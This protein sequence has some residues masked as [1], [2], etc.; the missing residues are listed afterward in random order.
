MS[1][2]LT[3]HI[4][5]HSSDITLEAKDAWN[6]LVLEGDEETG[7]LPLKR[8]LRSDVIGVHVQHDSFAGWGEDPLEPVNYSAA[9]H[10][11][12]DLPWPVIENYTLETSVV[13]Q[14][15]ADLNEWLGTVSN[16]VYDYQVGDF[17]VL[18]RG[19]DH[20]KVLGIYT[21][22]PFDRVYFHHTR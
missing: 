14:I 8:L 16:A 22:L 9:H 3:L 5:I 1:N 4:P 7:V 17:S 18:T 20:S 12:I 19:N 10:L 13:D 15:I 6:A 21:H 11:E 2:T